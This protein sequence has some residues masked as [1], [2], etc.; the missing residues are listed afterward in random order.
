M[1]M[2]NIIMLN[3]NQFEYTLA[4]INSVLNSDFENIKLLVI[5][6]GSEKK[7]YSALLNNLPKDNRLFVKRIDKNIGY[8]GGINYG[9][10]SAL[11]NE[12]DFFLIMNNDTIID[13]YAIKHLV[14]TSLQFENNCI[15]TGKVYRYDN[16]NLLETVGSKSINE[17]QLTFKNLGFNEI[18]RGQFDSIEERDMIDDIYWLIPS[19]V[20]NKL[21]NYDTDFFFNGESADYALRAKKEGNKLIY[22]PNAKLWHKG[23]LSVGGRNRNPYLNYWQMRSTLIFRYKHLPPKRFRKF[24]KKKKME[25]AKQ[26]LKEIA[27]L[28]QL[29]KPSPQLMRS[30]ISGMMDFHKYHYKK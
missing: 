20:Y 30:G 25:L 8:V 19:G 18:D 28:F 17:D 4:S 12:P 10:T 23:S 27:R 11:K 1:M 22:T 15:V 14:H 29:K 26:L 9:L 13:K 21:G 16:K 2:V 7:N 5:D 3:Y 24:Y 6:N